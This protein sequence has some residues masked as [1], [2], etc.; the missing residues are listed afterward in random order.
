MSESNPD[1]F[2]VETAHPPPTIRQYLIRSVHTEHGWVARYRCYPH[3]LQPSRF[4]SSWL[5]SNALECRLDEAAVR[6]RMCQ[7]NS[8]RWNRVQPARE[9]EEILPPV[10]I[11]PQQMPPAILSAAG[12]L[13]EAGELVRIDAERTDRRRE[14]RRAD[15]Y[16]KDA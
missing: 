2:A 15:E 11:A 1:E 4:E 6:W 10:K 7:R 8:G 16:L 12:E 13:V 9:K 5:V 14:Q 3:N